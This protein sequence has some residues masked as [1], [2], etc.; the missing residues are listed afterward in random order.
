LP[1]PTIFYVGRLEKRKGIKYLI[2]AFAELQRQLPDA[3]LL[4]GGDGS[5]REDLETYVESNGITNI[6]FLGYV[7]ESQK[8]RLLQTADVFCSPAIHGESF[9]I[10]LLESVACG[11]P[12][13]AGANP[14]YEYFL[15][16]RGALGLV[17]PKDTSDFA[18]RLHLMLTDEVIRDAWKAWAKDYIKE[19]DYA[20][21]VD[22]YEKLYTEAIKARKA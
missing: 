12:T 11:I 7:D 17:N 19:F 10:V 8:I 18:R 16:G 1:H 3:Q 13:V 4:I 2:T 21:I 20:H 14:G 15:Q 9:G 22:R 6:E 5:D